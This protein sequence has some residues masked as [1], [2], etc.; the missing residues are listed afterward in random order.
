MTHRLSLTLSRYI[1][2]HF[3][4]WLS[5]I[6]MTLATILFL[7]DLVEVLR[8]TA[9]ERTITFFDCLKLV[10]LKLP[11]SL[12]QTFS[13]AILF[14]TILS[15][16]SLT[17]TNELVAARAIG[18]SAGQFLFPVIVTAITIAI[19]KITIFSPIAS[20]TFRRYENLQYTLFPARLAISQ[21]NSNRLWLRELLKDGSII[22]HAQRTSPDLKE[23]QLVT[24]MQFDGQ[25][26]FV[27][28]LDAKTATLEPNIWRFYKVTRTIAGRTP[29]PSEDFSLSTNFTP[30]KISIS[31]SNP[32][33]ISF[34]ELPKLI[35]VDEMAGFSALPQRIEFQNHLATPLLYVAMILIGSVFSLRI[36]RRGNIGIMIAGGLA[37][38]FIFYFILNL[39]AALGFSG[40]I[41]IVLAVWSSPVAVTL[42]GIAALLHLE[43]G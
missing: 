28:R 33:S 36:S 43:D 1:A 18:V 39:V 27:A 17:R 22:I 4:I 8:L 15:Y 25:S 30:Q 42:L 23:L 14:A 24:V 34:W 26:N 31:L 41:P 3:L 11:T 7:G 2:R 21:I 32:E 19:I 12:Q 40:R 29:L 5:I 16:W 20:T 35:A 9:N 13:F 38:G 10:L 37:T 6:G